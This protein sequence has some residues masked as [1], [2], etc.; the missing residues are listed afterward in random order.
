MRFEDLNALNSSRSLGKNN[1]K[2]NSGIQYVY[3]STAALIRA[4]GRYKTVKAELFM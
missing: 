3:V 2:E 1:N 4:C